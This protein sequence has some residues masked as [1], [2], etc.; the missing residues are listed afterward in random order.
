MTAQA[1]TVYRYF[2]VDADHDV[3]ADQLDLSLDG[4]T[5]WITS[6][7]EYIP[8]ADLPASCTAK[9]STDPPARGYIGHWFRVLTGPGQTLPMRRGTN[10]VRGRLTDTPEIPY[11]TWTVSA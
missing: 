5:T 6:G 7:I 2:R 1:G 11:F 10:L 8:P 9:D 4:G 3:S